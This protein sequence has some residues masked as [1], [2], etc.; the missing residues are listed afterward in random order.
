MVCY[1]LIADVQLQ[2]ARADISG[3]ATKVRVQLILTTCAIITKYMYH[4]SL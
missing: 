3:H 1:R 4:L 2:H